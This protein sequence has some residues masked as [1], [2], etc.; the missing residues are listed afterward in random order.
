[1]Q[2]DMSVAGRLSLQYLKTMTGPYGLYQHAT[3]RVPLLS[4]GYC[5]D[6]N[7]RAVQTLV[8]LGEKMTIKDR[9]EVEMLL[10]RYW[11][12]VWEAQE[13]PGILFNF[14]D[15]AGRW[16][17]DGRS[18]DMYARVIRACTTVLSHDWNMKRRHQAEELLRQL[19]SKARTFTSLRGWAE[20]L[21]A[22][23]GLP[24]NSIAHDASNALAA[25]GAEFLMNAWEHNA[26][27]QWAWFEP[28]M[29]YGNALLPHGLLSLHALTNNKTALDILHKSA[30]F[31]IATTV[32]E[33]QFV[34]VGSRGWYPRGQA[35][36]VDNQQPI[37]A[38]TM[39]D[40]LLEYY[41]VFSDRVSLATVLAPYLWFFGQN[42]NGIVMANSSLGA[43]MDGLFLDGPNPN[44][45][46]ESMLAYLWAE[47]R[48][49]E[50]PTSVRDAAWAQRDK[51]LVQHRSH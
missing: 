51:L 22:L 4:E 12:F 35:P 40:F 30:D 19:F 46:A 25:Q 7:A 15:V 42:T 49:A 28:V 3:K 47:V 2:D 8:R 45:G 36:A 31:L 13:K 16:L 33:G 5:T 32:R 38:G 41:R 14:R 50:A 34:P 20:V 17:P 9:S 37:E 27:W 29:T 10:D 11:N 26:S 23:A 18:D 24:T 1:M 44:Y 21:V 6:D 39:I 48:L 43:C